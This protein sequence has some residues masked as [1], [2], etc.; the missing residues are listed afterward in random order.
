[1]TS[2]FENASIPI[3]P[4]DIDIIVLTHAHVDHSGMLPYL[5]ANGFRG[6]QKRKCSE[7]QS[8]KKTRPAENSKS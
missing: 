4:A 3:S 6:N 8:G 5:C 2:A 7:W 1:M